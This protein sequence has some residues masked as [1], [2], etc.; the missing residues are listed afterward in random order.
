MGPTGRSTNTSVTRLPRARRSSSLRT[1]TGT[2]ARSDRP[3]VGSL[4]AFMTFCSA[5]ATTASTTSFTV[6]PAAFFTSLNRITGAWAMAKRRF[7]PTRTSKG[8]RG[9]TPSPARSRT[10]LRTAPR[11]S[12]ARA[13]VPM[14]DLAPSA[15]ASSGCRTCSRTASRTRSTGPGSGS[16]FHGSGWRTVG[17]GWKSNIT[18]AMSTPEMPSIMA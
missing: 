14:A 18:V 17:S 5:P 1:E 11:P 8:P 6:P 12:R 4:R 10:P 15:N 9:G 2:M 13:G 3:L 7:G 16:G